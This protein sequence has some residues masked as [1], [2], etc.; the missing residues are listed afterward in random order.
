MCGIAGIFDPA[1]A[2]SVERLAQLAATMACTMQH[3]GPDDDG[4]WVDGNGGVA[5]GFRR[6]AIIDLSD[7]G[8]QPMRSPSGRYSMVF[9][10][11]IYNHRELRR[12]LGTGVR[13][14]GHSDTEVLLALMD[15]R[16]VHG[17]VRETKARVVGQYQMKAVPMPA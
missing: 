17:A 11:E 16:G 9:N 3:R 14:R 10:G 13:L 6:L 1:R 15:E 7:A 5:L 12:S 8:H 2:T 4:V